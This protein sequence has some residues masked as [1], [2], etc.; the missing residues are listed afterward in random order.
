MRP[1]SDALQKV[2]EHGFEDV[3]VDETAP[4][5]LRQY[6]GVDRVDAQ[7]RGL[8]QGVPAAKEL[9]HLAE[10]IRLALFRTA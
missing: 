5:A 9:D 2:S 6:L 7:G 4:G 1:G 8:F 3:P 10:Q